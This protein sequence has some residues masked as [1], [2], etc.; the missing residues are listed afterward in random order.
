[1]PR[2]W[3]NKD[4][5]DIYETPEGEQEQTVFSEKVQVPVEAFATPNEFHSRAITIGGKGRPFGGRNSE[6]RPGLGT[7]TRRNPRA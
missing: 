3:T 7:P 5:E 2:R 6:F 1:M 4:G